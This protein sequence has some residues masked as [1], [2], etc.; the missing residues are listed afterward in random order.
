MRRA[1]WRLRPR[2][3][4]TRPT[5]LSRPAMRTTISFGWHDGASSPRVESARRTPVCSPSRS[6]RTR[7]RSRNAPIARRSA[8]RRP[9]RPP[10]ES[11]APRPRRRPQRRKPVRWPSAPTPRRRSRAA[12]ACRASRSARPRSC[13]WPSHSAATRGRGRSRRTDRREA[14]RQ[15]E[16]NLQEARDQRA[17]GDL[18]AAAAAARSAVELAAESEIGAAE[19]RRAVAAGRRAGARC[20]GSRGASQRHATRRLS[21][22]SPPSG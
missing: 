17:A 13:S 6:L 15:I 8:L 7:A 21:L 11:S 16:R 22:S 10:P 18:G 2:P 5:L 3:T 14:A 4:S 20:A 9:V 19:R 1:A 12:R